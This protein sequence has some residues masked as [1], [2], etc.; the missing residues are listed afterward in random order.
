MSTDA[1][2]A[3]PSPAPRSQT[4]G[5]AGRVRPD[6]PSPYAAFV[7]LR[8]LRSRRTGFL[9]L[10]ALL[11][12]LGFT[13]G[14]ASLVIALALMAGF[15]NDVIAR[16]VGANAHVLVFPADAREV[17]TNPELPGGIVDRVRAVPGI[18]AAEPVVQGY[19]GVTAGG[20]VQWASITGLDPSGISAITDL[21]RQMVRGTVDDLARPT[22]TG[23]PGVLL[24]ARLAAR[25]GVVPGEPV[26]LI[27]PRPR[28]APWGPTVKQRVLEVAGVFETGYV[29]Y[30]ESWAFVTLDAGRS[31]FDV[32]SSAHW[33]AARVDDLGELEATQERLAATLGPGFWID[34]VIRRNRVFFSALRL[35][36]LLMGLAVGLIVL[37]AALG[38][39]STLVLTVTQKTREIGVLVSMGA[40]P[41]GIQS[42]FV[43][44]G[45]AMSVLGTL[46]GAG[47]GW[48][49]C[50]ALDHWQVI[51]LDPDVYYLEFLPFAVEPPD[52][53]WVVGLALATGLVATLYPAW[54][55]ARLDPV[56][57]LRRE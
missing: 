53:L 48:G 27:V 52:L 12:A 2:G 22:A 38:V 26:R 32:E 33:I 15:Q 13:L 8:F 21:E 56:E 20:T 42:I 29:E 46:L 37:V 28:L 40:T 25:L 39:V 19:A 49:L 50:A 18:D 4:D 44:Q 5:T 7:A 30:D 34:D 57:A 41:R 1:S 31:I 43:L 54:R 3:A 45:L 6:R 14:V 10:N 35:E 11:S 16:I 24:G 17:L 47:I 9:S 36:K 23:R 51:R 55:A